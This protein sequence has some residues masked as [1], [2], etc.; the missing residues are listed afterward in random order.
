M[1]AFDLPDSFFVKDPR[2]PALEPVP[3]EVKVFFA[4]T[5]IAS[6]KNALRILETTHPPTYYIPPAD[7]DPRFVRQVPGKSSYCEWKGRATYW[8]VL[9]ADGKVASA[10]AWS[11]PTPNNQYKDIAGYIAFYASPFDCYVGD[12]K[13]QAQE[14]DFYGGWKT[15]WI[16]GKMKGGPGTWGW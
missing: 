4:G 14:G 9:S 11:Y 1:S 10:R 6:T 7:I 8:D 15:S 3:Q 5:P 13:V 2:P 12:E 16:E